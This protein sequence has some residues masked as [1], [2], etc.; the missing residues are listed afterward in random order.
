MYTVLITG[1]TGL[2]GKALT[3]MLVE[4][5]HQVII[6][7]RNFETS[8]DSHVKY[9]MWDVTKQTV[10]EKAIREADYI[11]HL[12]GAGVADKR[13]TKSRKKEIVES[14]TLSSAL[15]VK[16][17]QTKPN[18]VKAI[19]SASA[20][21]WYGGDEQ[22]PSSQKMFTE[23]MPASSDFLGETCRLWE[24]SIDPVQTLG[25]RLVK[26]RTG[27][28]L[29]NEGGA[30]AEFKKPLKLGL[31]AIL[32]NGQQVISWIHIEDMCRLY[33]YAMEHDEINGVFN[34]VAPMPVK[35]KVLTVLL[36]KKVKGRFFIPM[37]VPGFVLKIMMGEMSTEVL[38][39]TTASSKKISETG[40]TFLYPSIE[41]AVIQLIT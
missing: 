36:A 1:G 35:N 3:K 20:I 31:A 34:A 37:N 13:W 2:I 12:A 7:S 10:D 8:K 9:A 18:K 38:K 32:G 40:F 26:L 22:R 24:Q 21:G 5:G 15:L 16:A 39:S 6:L 30:F 11:V 29:S 41:S 14:R 23:D 19:I 33:I 28:V 17:L 4:K 27:I 25:K